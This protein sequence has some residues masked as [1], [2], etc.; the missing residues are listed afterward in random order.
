MASKKLH[1]TCGLPKDDKKLHEMENDILKMTI[2][3]KQN[4]LYSLLLKCVPKEQSCE[5]LLPD[6]LWRRIVVNIYAI[7][8]R[9]GS[10]VASSSYMTVSG[11]GQRSMSEVAG[12]R[13]DKDD[14][15]EVPLGG[16]HGAAKAAAA[17][18]IQDI[19]AVAAASLPTIP[20]WA[21]ADREEI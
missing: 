18:M 17:I 16:R 6:R 10:W 2:K 8:Q 20:V 12:I 4:H 1:E 15:A 13:L 7:A 14:A 21:P 3:S 9:A 11:A 19:I 5:R